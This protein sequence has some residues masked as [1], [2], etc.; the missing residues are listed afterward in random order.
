MIRW[1][2]GESTTPGPCGGNP[3]TD[4]QRTDEARACRHRNGAY[5]FVNPSLMRFSEHLIEEARQVL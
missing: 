1:K 4:E 3:G 2:N 5:L